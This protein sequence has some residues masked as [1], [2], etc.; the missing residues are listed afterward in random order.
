VHIGESA[1]DAQWYP[2]C[3]FLVPQTAV[4]AATSRDKPVLLWDAVQGSCRCTYRTYNNADE[5]TACRSICFH[6]GGEKCASPLLPVQAH[7][8]LTEAAEVHS[9]LGS[10]A[11]TQ[12][13]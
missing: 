1:Y 5:V 11:R 8:L 7:V 3:N 12:A 10:D 4:F 2:A 9:R 13:R 6:P